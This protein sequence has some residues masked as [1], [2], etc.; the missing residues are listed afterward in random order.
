MSL[1]IGIIGG[2][3]SLI[4]GVYIAEGAH[5]NIMTYWDISAFIIVIVGT[6]FASMG[7]YSIVDILMIPIYVLQCVL[8][9][10]YKE[11]DIVESFQRMADK[12]KGGGK[13]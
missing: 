9:L 13:D 12:V 5:F 7:M 10:P 2:F 11:G 6:L 3:L 8:P 4:G 1:I